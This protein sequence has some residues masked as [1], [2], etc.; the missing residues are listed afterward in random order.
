MTQTIA[1]THAAPLAFYCWYHDRHGILTKTEGEYVFQDSETQ[2]LT[3]IEPRDFPWCT[4]NGEVGLTEAMRAVDAV[5]EAVRKQ[6]E[7]CP[8]CGLIGCRG[9]ETCDPRQLVLVQEVA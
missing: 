2:E 5:R 4:A 6:L 8:D 7:R 3:I 9:D 1:Q